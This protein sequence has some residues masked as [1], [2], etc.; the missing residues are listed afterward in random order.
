MSQVLILTKNILAEKEIQQKI[1][2]LNY[3][4]YCSSKLFSICLQQLEGNEFLNFFQYI[5]LS[6]SICES[7]VSVLVP[8][9]KKYSIKII[10]KVETFPTSMEQSYLEDAKLHAIIS[11]SE[12]NDELR[13]CLYQLE[14]PNVEHRTF[15][16]HGNRGNEQFYRR[17]PLVDST[18]LTDK[19]T[20]EKKIQ[21]MEVVYRLSQIEIKILTILLESENQIVDRGELCRKIW[22]DG[23]TKSHLASLSSMVSRIKSKFEDTSIGGSA[24]HTMWGK[25][26]RMEPKLSYEIKNDAQL[27]KNFQS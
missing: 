4:V 2:T 25:G 17:G 6:E 26:Y 19:M 13:E 1:Q 21:L 16:H 14:R 10:R 11:T 24:I 15:T 12:T 23:V 5:I 18:I 7:E 3:E 20:D 8:F 27:Y 22:N 9:L